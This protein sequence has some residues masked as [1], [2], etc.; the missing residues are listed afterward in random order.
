MQMLH[1]Q[2]I[3]LEGHVARLEPLALAHAA[4]LLAAAGDPRIWPYMPED[5]SASLA[6]MTG[7]IERSLA[8]QARGTD[9]PFTILW[10]ATGEI[11]GS[12]R[13]LNIMP[14]DRGL[15]IG[16]T[17]LA[18]PARRTALNTE[19]KYLLLRHAFEG[20]GAIRVQLKT[21]RRNEVSQ[22][23][24]ARIG[25][26][27]EGILRKHMIYPN[28]FQR[29]SVMYSITDDEWPAVKARLEGMLGDIL[30]KRSSES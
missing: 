12:T 5:P 28:G 26:V 15:E 20:L 23:A 18:S 16:W 30:G 11:A 3:A 10:R 21:D 1:V 25:A 22:R 7:W 13:Y 24:I 14:R 6:A 9:L 8:A 4:G 29:D 19:C 2:P 17:W 27:R